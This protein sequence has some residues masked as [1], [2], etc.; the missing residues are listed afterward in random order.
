M[1][2]LKTIIRHIRNFFELENEAKNN[3]KPIGAGNFYINNYI[4]YKSNGDRNNTLS[5]KEH[6]KKTRPYLNDVDNL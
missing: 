5:I 3:Y 4:E 1:K 2:E 6:L